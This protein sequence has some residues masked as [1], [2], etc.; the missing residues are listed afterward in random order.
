[1]FLFLD[2]IPLLVTINDNDD[3][4]QEEPPRISVASA[5]VNAI[6]DFLSNQQ[7]APAAADPI[8]PTVS[9]QAAE[10]II[11][12]GGIA[13]FRVHSVTDVAGASITVALQVTSVGD[14]FEFTQPHTRTVSLRGEDSTGL[15]FPTIDDEY[16]EDDGSI[17]LSIAAHS[18]YKIAENHGSA[19]V[20]VSDAID[21]QAREDF[22]TARAQEFLPDVVGNNA[23][24]TAETIE[25]RFQQAF[26]GTGSV[27]L[28]L[29]GQESIREMIKEGGEILNGSSTTLRSFLGESSFALTLLS[30]EQFAAPTTIWGIGDYRDLSPSSSSSSAGWEAES[31]TGHIGLDTMI[32]QEVLTGISASFNE[33]LIDFNSDSSIKDSLEY[34]LDTTSINPFIGWKSPT[35]DA[36]IRAIAGFGVGEFSV[37]QERYEVETLTSRSYSLALA[38]NKV[39]YSSDSI[40]NGTSQLSLVGESWMARQYIDGKDGVLADLQTDAQYYRVRTEGEHEFTFERGSRLTPKVSVGMRGDTKAEQSTVGMEFTGGINYQNPLGLTWDGA[41]SMLLGDENTVQKIS[42]SST[43]G[44]DYGNDKLGTILTL[45]PTWGQSSDDAQNNLWDSNILQ[46]DSNMGQYTNGTQVDSEIGYGFAIGDNTGILTLYSGY[47]FDHQVDDELML[48]TRVKIGSNFD[49]DVEGSQEIGT[50]GSNPTK[51]QFNG[52]LSW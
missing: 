49:F 40:L 11:D 5:A 3:P 16:A 37:D 38:G 36:E 48:G 15:F 31:F 17:T 6:L 20:I 47:E 9:I 23:A 35:D 52:R 2:L 28:N 14:F 8:L 25:M 4:G 21:R 39:L 33:N 43:F 24:R 44:F 45:A 50:E 12:E 51:V 1:M 42:A 30:A 13:G 32:G 26:S 41:G 22:V 27:V 34:A 7:P 18:S 19:T 29:G 46:D 10:L